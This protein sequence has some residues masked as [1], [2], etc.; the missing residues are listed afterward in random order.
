MCP[1]HQYLSHEVAAP[2]KGHD[3]YLV[4]GSTYIY[5]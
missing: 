5:F 1:W 4:R 2:H 3:Y